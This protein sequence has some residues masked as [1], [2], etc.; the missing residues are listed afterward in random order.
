MASSQ[1][2]IL[3]QLAGKI[4]TFYKLPTTQREA[5]RLLAQGETPP[6]TV[7]ANEQTDGYGR[8]SRR[9][10]SPP[11][12]IYISW[13]TKSVRY[14]PASLVI[15]I[16]LHRAIEKIASVRAM[17][18]WPNDILIDG[19]KT[20]GILVEIADDTLI[21]GIGMNTF[22][23]EK[24]PGEIKNLAITIAMNDEQ[25]VKFITE[26]FTQ[27]QSVWHKFC[28]DGFTVLKDEYLQRSMP[29][30]TNLSLTIGNT[31]EHGRYAGVSNEGEIILITGETVRR[32]AIGEAS[33]QLP[34]GNQ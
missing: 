11:N 29:M 9:W 14:K 3:P 18:K 28:R 33:I 19:R 26:F 23:R 20:A 6:F 7:I 2:I 15:A 24:M 10:L 1:E 27:L 31:T 12:G 34:S 16:P 25:R 4:F 13:V 17:I 32:F 22:E 30:G 5:R 8:R 21:A